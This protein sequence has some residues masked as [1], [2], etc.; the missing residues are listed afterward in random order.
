MK[1]IKKG[2]IRF[3]RFVGL[4]DYLHRKNI[5]KI[6]KRLK[7]KLASTKDKD[8]R[9]RAFADYDMAFEDAYHEFEI[10]NTEILMRNVRKLRVNVPPRPIRV[11]FKDGGAGDDYWRFSTIYGEWYLTREGFLEVKKEMR[12]ELR[13]DLEV[14]S[15]KGYW[16]N[17]VVGLIGAIT[18]LLAVFASIF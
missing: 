8:K 5:Q 17:P 16:I 12:S 3:L 2:W 7:D 14:A 15:L 9:D 10:Y 18:G 6:D 1:K 13:E 11:V 4:N